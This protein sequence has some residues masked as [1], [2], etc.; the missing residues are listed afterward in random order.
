M[1]DKMARPEEVLIVED[2]NGEIVKE[3]M[4]D[5]DAIMLYKSMRETLIYL[6][7]LNV[8][9]TETIMQQKLQRQVDGSEWDWNKLNTL[10]WAIGSISGAMIEEE[11]KRFLVTARSPLTDRVNGYSVFFC[12]SE[13]IYD[14]NGT[15]R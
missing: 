5:T 2:D 12:L 15:L 9:N 3:V 14:C 11:E 13:S 10:C 1:I 8:D 4:K 6:T 7:N